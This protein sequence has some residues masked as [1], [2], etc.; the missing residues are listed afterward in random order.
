MVHRAR[1]LNR[2]A[3][4][5]QDSKDTIPFSSKEYEGVFKNFLNELEKEVKANNGF[6]TYLKETAE[7][8]MKHALY[9][10]PHAIY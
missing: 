7:L 8:G 5:A 6:N 1:S 4:L 9:P 2:S 10:H 3:S